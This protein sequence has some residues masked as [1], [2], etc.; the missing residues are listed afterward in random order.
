M[1]IKT[2]LFGD[3]CPPWYSETELLDKISKVDEKINELFI[4]RAEYVET[5]K[6]SIKEKNNIKK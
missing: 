4:I 2:Q 3:A 5:L 6:K 1:F